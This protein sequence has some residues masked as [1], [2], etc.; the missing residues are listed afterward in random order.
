ARLVSSHG[1]SPYVAPT[2][3]IESSVAL[4]SEVERFCSVITDRQVKYAIFMTGPGV[5]ALL[6]AARGLGKEKEILDALS[7]VRVIARSGKPK[8]ALSKH[9]IRVDLVP[10]EATSDGILDLLRHHDVKNEVVV[11]L[12][13]GSDSSYLGSGLRELGAEVIAFSTYTYS[14]ETGS[15]GAQ[16]LDSMRFAAVLP[17][18][19]DVVE[20]IEEIID[21][22]ID[23]ITFTSPPSANN[24]F[25]VASENGRLEPL[26]AALNSRVI[27]VA[28]G[29]P[30]R[31]SVEAGGVAVD[32]VPSVY[33]MGPMIK[34]MCEYVKSGATKKGAGGRS[35]DLPEK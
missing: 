21:E 6:S 24:L 1:G 5:Y 8:D 18:K 10:P 13:H 32:V 4:N 28:V 27:V 31:A 30:T 33:K 19:A 25:S 35:I 16:I 3:G 34:A 29:P 17:H 12:S 15:S 23:A 26:R 14:L 22:R 7:K 9:G 20:L 2:V 11:V